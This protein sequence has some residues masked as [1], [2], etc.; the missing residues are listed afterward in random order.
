MKP[1]CS[2]VI[3]CYNEEKHIGRLLSGIMQQTLEDVEIIL[4]DSGSTDA[5][6]E[7]ARRFPVQVVH[8]RKEEFSFGRSLNMGC[9][10]ARGDLLVFASAHVYPVYQ[11]WLAQILM[12]FDDD[13]V[14]LVYGKQRG[15]ETTK[16]SEHRVFAKWFPEMSDFRQKQPFCNN[17]NT[18]IRRKLWEQ[19]AYDEILTGLEDLAWAKHIIEQGY[20][21]AYNADAEIIHVHDETF[22]QVYNR[23]RREAIAFKHIYPTAKFTLWDFMRLFLVNML[24]DY[25]HAVRDSVFMR[26]LSGIP[27]F[28]W[29][30]FLGTYHGYREHRPITRQ[31]HQ[32]FYYPELKRTDTDSISERERLRITYH[33]KPSP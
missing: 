30:Q 33:D 16:Y 23:Y 21:L 14:A 6:L 3:R 12:P 25:S 28:R 19:Y 7:I 17:A 18:A 5:T 20:H 15:A 13:R 8:I 22:A 1:K 24:N 27:R 9:E 10:A 11:D 31:L 4:V 26:E 2:I 32:T 29:N